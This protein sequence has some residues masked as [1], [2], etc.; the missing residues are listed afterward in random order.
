[1]RL[2]LIGSAFAAL[3]LTGVAQAAEPAAAI[4]L[5]AAKVDGKVSVE[6]AL[7][8]R[9]SLRRPSPAALSL[10]EIAQLAWSAQGV[11]DEKGHRTAPSAMATYPLELYVLAGS[12]AGLAPGLYRYRPEKHDLVLV[13]AGDKRAELVEK[14]IGQDWILKAPAVF[15]ITGFAE[16]MEAKI[17]ERSSSFIWVEAGLAA[18]SFFLEA[19]ALGMGS[20]YVGGFK[21]DA[22]R[23]VLGLAA[24]EEPLAVLPVGKK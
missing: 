2:V 6:K 13:A 7:K 15:V 21:P 3:L 19:T 4:A 18:Q 23:S 10:A 14:A 24:G 9:R 11:T 22:T 5:P 17:K 8:E 1:M 12:V 16:R 20:T